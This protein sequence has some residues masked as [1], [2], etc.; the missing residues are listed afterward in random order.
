MRRIWLLTLLAAVVLS[1]APARAGAETAPDER[2]ILAELFTLNR[3]LEES[4]AEAARLGDQIATVEQKQAEARAEQA[5][6]EARYKERQAFYGKRLRYYS[7][8]GRLAPLGLLF[9]AQS[10]SDFLFRLDTLSTML[11]LDAR[12]MA[13]MRLLKAGITRQAE[14]LSGQRTELI[15]LQ[16]QQQA[17]AEKLRTEIARKEAILEAA[18]DRRADL[19]AKLAELERQWAASTRPLLEALG[20]ALQKSTADLSQF[21]PDAVKFSLFPPQATVEISARTLNQ[22]LAGAP[23]LRALTVT[24]G[25][26]QVALS[27][28]FREVPLHIEGGFVIAGNAVLRFE[29]RTVQIEGLSLPETTTRQVLAG[30]PLE[31]DFRRL[32]SPGRLKELHLQEDLM[33]IKTGF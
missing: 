22:F 16:E 17:T 11:R 13:D 20:A 5:R 26:G 18:R 29:P 10:L 24:I 15:H 27:G 14:T 9:Q 33:V 8:N 12:V 31:L 30:A 4:Q 7:E 6:L 32:V 3:S 1:A 2:A 21:E 25:E 23:E 28:T 19:E